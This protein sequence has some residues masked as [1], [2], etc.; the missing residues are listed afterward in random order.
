MR[1][2][3]RN[4]AYFSVIQLLKNIEP[5]RAEVFVRESNGQDQ[6]C[7]WCMNYISI[8]TAEGTGNNKSQRKLENNNSWK[9]YFRFYKII[10]VGPR[11]IFCII[12]FP[13]IAPDTEVNE[14]IFE[15][16]THLAD[17]AQLFVGG[18]HSCKRQLPAGSLT[19]LIRQ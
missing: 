9:S 8:D 2:H 1:N 11:N 14:S 5:V 15:L 17:L 7:Y 3:R 18:R 19:L 10:T 12:K 13:R 6:V 4:I 16:S